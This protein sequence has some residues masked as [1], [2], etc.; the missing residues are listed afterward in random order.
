MMRRTLCILLSLAL[1]AACGPRTARKP[2]QAPLT[3]AFPAAEVPMMYTQPQER[4]QWLVQHF[5]DGFTDPAVL[6]PCDSAVVNGVTR[7]DLETQMG[8]Y[9][10]LL[11]NVSLQDAHKAV[12]Q[13][14]GKLDRF[15]RVHPEG[16]LFPALCELT[17]KYLYDP[18]SPVRSEDFYLPFVQALSQSDLVPEAQRSRHA[19]E[20]QMCALNQTG[21]RAANFTFVDTEGRRRTLYGIQ[22]PLTLLIFGNP[23]CQACREIMELLSGEPG[24]AQLIA[25]GTLKVV[26]VYIDEDIDTWK[27]RKDSYPHAWINGYDPSFSIRTDLIYCVRAIPSL[28]LLDRDKRVVLKDATTEAL[29]DALQ[30]YV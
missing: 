5:W 8:M 14:Y 19:W 3:R 11:R 21:T 12:T 1:L 28:Y 24:A 26:D 17:A 6:Y 29:L 27:A 9:T 30:S 20:A 2:V 22:A 13:F 10:T 23:D 7:P 15:Q 18:N 25:G 16:N 4:I